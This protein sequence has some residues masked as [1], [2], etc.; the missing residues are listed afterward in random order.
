MIKETLLDTQQRMHSAVEAVG[1][2]L[3]SVRTGRANISILDE[4]VVDYYGAPT[5]L[6]QLAG[7]SAPEPQLLLL[8]PYDKGSIGAIEKAILQSNL[9]LNPSNDGAVMRIPIPSLTEERRLELAKVVAEY[10]E[11]GKTAVRQVRRDANDRLKKLEH[12]KDI[13]QDEERQ[14]HDQVQA[15]TDRFCNEIDQVVEK[16]RQEL[17]TI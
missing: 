15:L 13:S 16:R 14:A 9:G 17:L 8:Q 11:D 2:E 3:R 1:R 7:L 5:P 12:D 10:G 6:N 4:V